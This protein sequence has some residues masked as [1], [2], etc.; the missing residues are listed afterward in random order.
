MSTSNQKSWARLR[1]ILSNATIAAISASAIPAATADVAEPAEPPEE[2]CLAVEPR[3]H[4][5][6]ATPD[7]ETLAHALAARLTT[8]PQL[9]AVGAAAE[10]ATSPDAR[11]RLV[12]A[13]ALAWAF[14]LP[15][16]DV[17]LSHL[18]DDPDPRVRA[19]IA[20]AAWAR[21]AVVG[22]TGIL[23]R[24]LGDADPDV[25]AAAWLAVRG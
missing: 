10:L 6:P 5:T 18:A 16:D 23:R 13:G 14:P 2:P 9:D 22:D 19:A 24:L 8:L 20:R 12:L 1:A 17:L 11:E 15:S 7:L 4:S 3:G 21:I 25:R